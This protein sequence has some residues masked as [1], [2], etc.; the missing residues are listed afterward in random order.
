MTRAKQKTT[1]VGL[2]DLR[3]N[4]EKY[5]SRIN[6]G[7]SFT[8]IRRSQPVFRIAPVDEEDAWQ[9]V[10]DLTEINKNGVSAREV[11][12]TLKQLNA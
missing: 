11:L 1:T 3:M 10:V 5:I 6:K 8:V 7:E 9:T 2:K 4:L 12:R